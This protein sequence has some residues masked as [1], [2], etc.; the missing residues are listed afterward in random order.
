MLW[1]AARAGNLPVMEYLS[2]TSVRDAYQQYLD[3]HKTKL[4]ERIS[5][6]I[7]DS[8]EFKSLLGFA[9]HPSQGSAILAAAMWSSLPGLNGLMAASPTLARE[10]IRL[11]TLMEGVTPLLAICA[12]LGTPEVFDWLVEHGADIEVRDNQGYVT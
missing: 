12:T 3:N 8:N 11:R 2:T 7:S 1:K 4:G 6:V 5:A 9:V 10:G